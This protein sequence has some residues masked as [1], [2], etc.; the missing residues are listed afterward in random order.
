M[1]KQEAEGMFSVSKLFKL[2]ITSGRGKI[3]ATPDHQ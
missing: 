3:W 1:E 2:L